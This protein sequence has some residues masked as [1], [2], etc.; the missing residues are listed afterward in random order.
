ML[1]EIR[2]SLA[3]QLNIPIANITGDSRLIEDL[4]A[5][6]LDLVELITGL[7]ERYGIE[8]PEED[9]PKTQW[10][11]DLDEEIVNYYEELWVKVKN[12]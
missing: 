12:S 1:N 10:F 5:D 2:E 4:K 11:H 7:E 6:S 8:I 9:M 3:A